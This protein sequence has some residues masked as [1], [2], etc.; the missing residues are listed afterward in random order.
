MKLNSD[1]ATLVANEKAKCVID[2]P[3][4]GRHTHRIPEPQLRLPPTNA[5]GEIGSSLQAS[6][7][8]PSERSDSGKR[9]ATVDEELHTATSLRSPETTGNTIGTNFAY[10]STTADSP[11]HR[12]NPV[13]SSE[14][15][16]LYALS[17]RRRHRLQSGGDAFR[18]PPQLL[19]PT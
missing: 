13:L 1:P 14:G 7:F 2:Q 8:S 5:D 15:E 10:G 6:I 18:R 12:R 17:V 3:A 11:I 4:N 16:V 9:P 19:I